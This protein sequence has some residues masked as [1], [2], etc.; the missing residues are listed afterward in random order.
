MIVDQADVTM[1]LVDF[2]N[3]NVGDTNVDGT[4]DAA[5]IATITANI[6]TLPATW[7]R[8]NMDGNAVIDAADLALANT[9]LGQNRP[10]CS[11]DLDDG[12]GT[13]VSD[14]GVDINDLLYF[15]SKFEAGSSCVDVDNG[16]LGGFPDG[17]VDINDLLYFLTRFEGGC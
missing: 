16:S 4:V 17:G 5:D 8:G 13:G 14:G 1:V 10:D 6:G 3:T 15:L 7:A 11:A 9:N 12:S 2:L